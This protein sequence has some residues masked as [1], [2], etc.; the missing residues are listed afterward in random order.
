MS[1]MEEKE[2]LLSS[3]DY[4]NYVQQVFLFLYEKGLISLKHDNVFY[5]DKKIYNQ[6]KLHPLEQQ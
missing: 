2:I 1:E 6:Y 3:E 5:S 4:I